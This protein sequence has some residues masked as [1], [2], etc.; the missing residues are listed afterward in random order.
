[1]EV[2]NTDTPETLAA[3]ILPEE[4]AALVQSLQWLSE[5]KLVVTGRKVAKS[6]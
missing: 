4:H 2:L 3:R 6:D 5:G 1:V